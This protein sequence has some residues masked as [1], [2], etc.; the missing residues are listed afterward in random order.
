M[1]RSPLQLSAAE[2]QREF[3]ITVPNI[4]MILGEERLIFDIQ[5]G[6][7]V[8]LGNDQSL[9]TPFRCC[10]VFDLLLDVVYE[11]AANPEDTT[12]LENKK[13]QLEEENKSLRIKIDL[14]MNMLAES[15]AEEELKEK[16]KWCKTKISL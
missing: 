9:N 8:G 11:A 13:Q 16:R 7:W 14:L 6:D 3:G 12:A 2:N 15:M 5:K 4:D 1:S 10:V